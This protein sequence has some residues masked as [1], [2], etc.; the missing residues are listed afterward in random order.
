MHSPSTLPIGNEPGSVTEATQLP[1]GFSDTST[2]RHADT[3]EARL[4]VVIGGA[5]HARSINR[6]PRGHV[7]GHAI[8]EP[9]PVSLDGVP[10][11]HVVGHAIGEP[12]PVSLDGRPR[13]HVVGHAIAE[14]PRR[15]WTRRPA[16]TTSATTR[17]R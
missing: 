5:S 15:H 2:S 7:V 12:L 13:G 4:H 1:D 14:P 3:A 11:G 8:G 6:R 16:V 17:A 9:L 10:R